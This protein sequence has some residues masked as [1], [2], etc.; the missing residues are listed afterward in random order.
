[1]NVLRKG[2]KTRIT[3]IVMGR[4]FPLYYMGKGLE[5]SAILEYR[6]PVE[7][8]IAPI[9]KYYSKRYMRSFGYK[10]I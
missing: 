1:M 9:R 8:N 7:W 10:C 2:D 5:N 6:L 3:V 4:E